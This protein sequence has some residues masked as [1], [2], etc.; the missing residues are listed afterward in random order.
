MLNAVLKPV[1]GAKFSK[2][3]S[4][5]VCVEFT[6]CQY[7]YKGKDECW[8]LILQ[9][10]QR[11]EEEEIYGCQNRLVSFPYCRLLR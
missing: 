6:C 5:P 3:V 11:K 8:D 7:L 10:R 9:E 4:G 1:E 2:N